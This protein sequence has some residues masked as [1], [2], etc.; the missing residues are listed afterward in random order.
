MLLLFQILLNAIMG[1]TIAMTM[2]LALTH[3][4]VL[5]VHVKMAILVMV[6]HVK[7]SNCT[8]V[9]YYCNLVLLLAQILMNA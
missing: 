2:L 4:E 8:K 7:V 6:V 1:H 9:E 3:L 5:Y